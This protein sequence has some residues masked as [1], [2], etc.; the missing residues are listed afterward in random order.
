MICITPC[1]CMIKGCGR[2]PPYM[3]IEECHMVTWPS[4]IWALYV[5]QALTSINMRVPCLVSFNSLCTMLNEFHIFYYGTIH[6]VRSL[7]ISKYLSFDCN[8]FSI[9]IF[10][11]S[12]N[13]NIIFFLA[14]ISMAELFPTA[15]I[16]SLT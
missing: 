7:L 16:G 1:T 13:H 3:C 12:K 11:S 6:L 10:T 4:L 15:T 8:C 2:L 14:F 9:T 5:F